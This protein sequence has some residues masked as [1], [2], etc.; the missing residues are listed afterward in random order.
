MTMFSIFKKS[1][2]KPIRPV[3]IHNKAK[4]NIVEGFGQSLIEQSNV[5]TQNEDQIL[6]ESRRGRLLN[7][8]RNLIRNSSLFNTILGQLTTNVVSSCGGKVILNFQNEQLNRNLKKYFSDFTRNSDYYNGTTFNHLLKN[9]LREVIVGGDCVLLFD[10]GC[11]EGSGKIL[12]FESDE[13]VNTTPAVIEEHYGKGAYQSLGKV[14][15]PSGRH[16]GTVV[17]RSQRGCDIADADKC[18]FLHRDPNGNPLES[19]WFQPANQWRK[20]RAVSQAASAVSTIHQLEDL[21]TSELLAARRNSQ[22]FCWLTSKSKDAE[23]LPSTFDT[24]T[25]FDSMTDEDIEKAVN[26]EA[27]QT[28]TISFQR[29]RENSVVYEALPEDYDARQLDT[30]H[31]NPSVETMV[32]WLAGRAAATLGLSRVF[33]TG[34]PEDSNFRA[35]QLMTQGAI[36]EFQKELEQICDWAFYQ[37]VKFNNIVIEEENFMTKVSWQWKGI[38]SLDPVTN[39]NANEMKLRNMTSNYQEILG[40]DWKE[41]LLQTASE[42]KWLKENNLPVPQYFL[43]SGGE[44]TG[45]EEVTSE[46]TEL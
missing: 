35:N 28:Q 8:T 32:N 46:T 27:E 13:I 20:G 33:V 1:N 4:Y 45:S 25:D 31:P 41:K 16:I 14:Y 44:A 40:N 36:I 34:S 18:Y 7:V 21:V 9:I 42:I 22:I 19:Y 38:D 2:K 23:E 39:E 29:A 15:S 37:V 17:S 24:D 30:K 3:R 6:N 26:E 43:K 10:D 5:E 11:I 12:L